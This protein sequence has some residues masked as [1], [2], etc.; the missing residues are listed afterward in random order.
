M[1]GGREVLARSHARHLKALGMG[2]EEDRPSVALV[3]RVILA[4]D[5]WPREVCRSMGVVFN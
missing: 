2:R 5:T 4:G 3:V 1:I